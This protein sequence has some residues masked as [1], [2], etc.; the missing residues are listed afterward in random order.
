M[1]DVSVYQAGA[2]NLGEIKT[3]I[4]GQINPRLNTWGNIGVQMGDKGY[5]DAAA[6]LGLKYNF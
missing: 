3:G 4:E 2:R 1:D 6:M 5:H